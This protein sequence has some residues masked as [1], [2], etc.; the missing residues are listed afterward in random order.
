[1]ILGNFEYCVLPRDTTNI[2]IVPDSVGGY[3]LFIVPDSVGGYSLF[4]IVPDSVGG[5]SLFVSFVCL[6]RPRLSRG[7]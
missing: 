3:S 2:I 7:L 1:M 5:Y 6:Y 4:V